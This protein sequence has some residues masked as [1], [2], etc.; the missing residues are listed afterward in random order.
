VR[1]GDEPVSADELQVDRVWGTRCHHVTVEV[2]PAASFQL[3]P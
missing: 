1:P 3:T 2:Q